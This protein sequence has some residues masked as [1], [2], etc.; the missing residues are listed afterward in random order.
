MAKNPWWGPDG[1]LHFPVDAV[2]EPNVTSSSSYGGEEYQ[3]PY[4][5]SSRRLYAEERRA[6]RGG[7]FLRLLGYLLVA[8]LVG[9]GIYYLANVHGLKWGHLFGTGAW[10]FASEKECD[11]TSAFVRNNADGVPVYRIVPN[12]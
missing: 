2:V 5:R 6:E 10:S 7:G 11:S 1:R 12:C 9:A 4:R 3:Q 8:L